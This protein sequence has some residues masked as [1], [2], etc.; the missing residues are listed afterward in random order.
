MSNLVLFKTSIV[1]RSSYALTAYL[2]LYKNDII[3]NPIIFSDYCDIDLD[4]N[5]PVFNAYFLRHHFFKHSILLDFDDIKYLNNLQNHKCI[6]L[7]NE[8][9]NNKLS[10]NH[11]YVL[12]EEQNIIKDIINEKI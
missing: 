8:L 2:N 7:C 4:S 5:I 6:V 3:E 12:I 10:D 9:P 11:V 1:D